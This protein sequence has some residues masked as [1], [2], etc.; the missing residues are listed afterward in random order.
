MGKKEKELE[1]GETGKCSANANENGEEEEVLV[2]SWCTA[3]PMETLGGHSYFNLSLPLSSGDPRK[4][5]LSTPYSFILHLTSSSPP[6]LHVQGR[7]GMIE[8]VDTINIDDATTSENKITRR[9]S[10]RLERYKSFRRKRISPRG[11]SRRLIN[12]IAGHRTSRRF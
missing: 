2:D 1:T 8:T 6:P 5:N 10:L 11:S 7:S 9:V 12:S 3:V 4:S